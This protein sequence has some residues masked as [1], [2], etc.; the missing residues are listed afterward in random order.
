[1]DNLP[2]PFLKALSRARGGGRTYVLIH[3][4]WHGGWV[5]G[6]LAARLRAA[7]H[8]V[9]APS[10]TGLGDRRHLLRPGVNLT[11]HADDI[12]NL[13]ELEELNRIVLVGWSYGGMVASE[14]LARIPERIASVVYLDAFAPERGRSLLSYSSVASGFENAVQDAIQGKDIAPLSCERMGITDPEV[15]AYLTPKLTP[16]PVMTF[17]Q[18]SGA[19][20]RRPNIPHTYVL[21]N[22]NPSL[23]FKTFHAALKKEPNVTTHA[24]D[25]DHLMMLTALDLTFETLI[26]AG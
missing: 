7:G 24:L 17:L 25:V 14:V 9:F 20:E 18:T 8:D 10:L 26:N 2:S 21:A 4:A 15:T 5:W 23:T 12:V 19:L 1:M 3:G 11:T 22:R 16:Q 6:P 13:I